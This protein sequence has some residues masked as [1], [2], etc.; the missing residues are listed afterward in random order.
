M[1]PVVTLRAKWPAP[2][3]HYE[4]STRPAR[5][6][7]HACH[8]RSVVSEAWG[9]KRGENHRPASKETGWKAY[10][11]AVCGPPS[12]TGIASLP[13]A[14]RNDIFATEQVF[15]KTCSILCALC[16]LCGEFLQ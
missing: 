13:A 5:H 15:C 7:Y 14:P 12:V 9:V 10:P 11:T 3:C 4:H 1:T 2:R 16:R 8:E 6:I